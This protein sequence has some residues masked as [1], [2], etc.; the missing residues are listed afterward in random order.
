MTNFCKYLIRK[1]R[2]TEEQFAR[3]KSR[4]K[5]NNLTTGLCAY[6]FG[7]MDD[8]QIRHVLGMQRRTGKKFGAIAV[9][10]GYLT[11]AQLRTVLRIQEKYLVTLEEMLVT[12]GART[13]EELDE[14]R[15][16]FDAETAT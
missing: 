6:A 9:A 4:M 13:V 7:F 5:Q 3:A 10:L 11:E 1:G 2:I 15:R 8:P 14:E 16:H 12:E